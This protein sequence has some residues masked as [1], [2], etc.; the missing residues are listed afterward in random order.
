MWP[1]CYLQR[2]CT[3]GFASHCPRHHHHLEDGGILLVPSG[4][5]PSSAERDHRVPALLPGAQPAVLHHPW[6]AVWTEGNRLQLPVHLHDGARCHARLLWIVVM[7]LYFFVVN[8]L[9]HVFNRS[10]WK[11][12]HRMNI[13]SHLYLETSTLP[14]C[15][16]ANTKPWAGPCCPQCWVRPSKNVRLI[17]MTM[18]KRPTSMALRQWNFSYNCCV[19]SPLQALWM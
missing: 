10:A 6:R 9:S 19:L 17:Y 15:V 12:P 4:F 7:F 16:A 5:R 11:Q 2:L 14:V 1:L 8:I 3:D 13:P 18:L